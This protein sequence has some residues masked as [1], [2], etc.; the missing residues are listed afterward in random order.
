[1]VNKKA[2]DKIIL[3]TTEIYNLNVLKKLVKEYITKFYGKKLKVGKR[4]TNYNFTSYQRIDTKVTLTTIFD[5]FDKSYGRKFKFDI[6]LLNKKYQ[7]KYKLRDLYIYKLR[8]E[9]YSFAQISDI[10][11]MTIGRIKQIFYKL[12]KIIDDTFEIS[13]D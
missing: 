9:G 7:S 1:M 10:L 2:T 8:K 12:K 3:S 5:K 4:I 6:K 13:F 11:N